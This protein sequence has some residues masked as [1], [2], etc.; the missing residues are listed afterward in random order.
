MIVIIIV[1]RIHADS[2]TVDHTL[3]NSNEL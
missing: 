1:S 3:L 2:A